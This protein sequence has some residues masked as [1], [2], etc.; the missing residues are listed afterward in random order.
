[1]SESRVVTVSTEE[2]HQRLDLFLSRKLEQF[3][4]SALQRWIESGHVTVQVQ[5]NALDSLAALLE[6]VNRQIA[7]IDVL[8][9]IDDRGL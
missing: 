2:A 4:R 6:D 5:R 9:G 1:M 7:S 3:S 8:V